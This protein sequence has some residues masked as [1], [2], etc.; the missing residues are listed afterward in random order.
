MRLLASIF[1]FMFFSVGFLHSQIPKTEH[2]VFLIGDA[3]EPKLAKNNLALL[4]K[5]IENAGKEATLIFLGDNIYEKGLSDEDR[6][7]RSVQEEKLIRQLEITKEFKGRTIVIPGNHDWAKGK[8]EGWQNVTNQSQFVDQYFGG[9]KSFYPKNGFPGPNEIKLDDNL[10]LIVFDMQWMLHKWD[11]PLEKNPFQQTGPLDIIV[12]IGKLL[13]KHKN[14]HVIIAAHHPLNSYG[15]H[16]GKYSFKSHLFPLTE[17]NSNLYIPL[18]LIGSLYPIY[19]STAGAIQDIPHPQYKAVRNAIEDLVKPYPNVIYVAGHEHSLQHIEKNNLHQIVSGSGSKTTHLKKNGKY[20]KFGQPRVGFSKVQYSE[21]KTKLEFWVADDKSPDG[22]K[23]YQAPLYQF[24]EFKDPDANFPRHEFV[25]S[26]KTT[27]ASAQYHASKSKKKWMGTNY[28]SLWA[29]EVKAPIIDISKEHGGLKIIKKGGGQQTNSLRLE[30]PDG[31]QYVLRSVEKYPE[32]ALPDMLKETIAKNVVQDQIS[33]S[34]PYAAYVI[35]PMAESIGIYHTNPKLVFIPND[36]VFGPFRKSFANTLA[37][38]EERP[39]KDWSDTNL[40]GSSSDLVNTQKVIE[41]LRKDNDNRVDEKFVLKNRLFDMV[42]ADWD[43][44]EDQWRWASFKEEKGF[45]YKPVPRDR[46]QAF[47][48]NEGILPKIATA[49]FSMPKIE[50]FNPDMKWAPGFNFNARY[51]DRFFMSSTS[52]Q[53]WIDAAAEIQANLTDEIIENAIALWPQNVYDEVG[54]STIDILKARRDNLPTYSLELYEYLSREV[55][56][57]CS[58]KKELILVDNMDKDSVSVKVK[59]ISK[60][61]KEAQVTFD[62]VFVS[63]ETKEVRIYGFGSDDQIRITGDVKSKINIRV[64][65][66]KGSDTFTDKTENKSGQNVKIY[67]RKS[68]TILTEGGT[69]FKSRLSKKPD[70]NAYDKYGYKYGLRVPLIYGSVN[71]DDG[72]LIGGGTI[73]VNQGWRK[74][75]FSSQHLFLASGSFTTGAF[76]VKYKGA[77]TD[78]LWK[79]NLETLIDIEA[80]NTNNFF[81]FGNESVHEYDNRDISYY[82]LRLNENIYRLALTHPIGQEGFFSFGL[83]HKGVTVKERENT[84]LASPEF[85]EFDTDVLFDDLRMYTGFY[86]GLNFDTRDQSML[87][88]RGLH[89]N[90]EFVAYK[91]INE[92]ANNYSSLDSELALYYSFSFP[93]IV[94]LASRTGYSH[95][96]GDFVLDEFYN[97]SVLGGRTNLRGF[98]KTR[99]YGRT[100]FYQN[101]DMR[102]KLFDFSSFLF[103]G[104]FGMHGFYDI[105]RVWTEEYSDV[106]HR[107]AGFGLWVAPLSKAVISVSYGFTG[108]ENLGFIDFGFFF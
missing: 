39:A 5:Q 14:D 97:A 55:E 72:L 87:P 54:Q 35:P 61:G 46:D 24:Q 27:S 18:P 22:E 42:I 70:V 56:V 43:R 44:H 83:Q 84:Y 85:D 49:K 38:Y 63:N 68:T 9:K 37:L 69:S 4:K 82:R 3:G 106:W 94:T 64:I 73:F 103:P 16:G 51:F 48:M 77:Y 101:V 31:K 78:V 47:F 71:P 81:G 93:A 7:D 58:D 90:T 32:N 30:A 98:R 95:R 28:R 23:I 1:Y 10:F 40:F 96:F 8:K 62:R 53:D 19:R 50:G 6:P 2:T 79:W 67:D 99:F 65:G 12:D 20:L 34:N 33:A 91:G 80:P 15:P 11:K 57:L 60:K 107:S 25:D 41:K 75:P 92:N 74:E 36:G 66:G 45:L 21:K 104:K 76:N 26:I 29:M 52:R 102:I 86:S 89:W 59:K 105:G 88:T 13:E 108:E 17:A 100:S